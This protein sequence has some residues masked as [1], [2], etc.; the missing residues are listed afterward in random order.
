M[1]AQLQFFFIITKY[2]KCDLQFC[3]NRINH[4]DGVTSTSPYLGSF[5]FCGLKNL[6]SPSFSPS[7]RWLYGCSAEGKQIITHICDAINPFS[8]YHQ[9]ITAD[10]HLSLT[11]SDLLSYMLQS[12]MNNIYL[13]LFPDYYTHKNGNHNLN[14]IILFYPSLQLLPWKRILHSHAAPVRQSGTGELQ[15]L[16]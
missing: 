4:L 1:N 14:D 7:I 12:L 13:A 8:F 16:R 2:L 10:T 5:N 15:S 9:S 6:I 3:L 11:H